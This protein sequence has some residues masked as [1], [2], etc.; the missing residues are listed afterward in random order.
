MIFSPKKNFG[1]RSVA[2]Q[3]DLARQEFRTCPGKINQDSRKP[4]KINAVPCRSVTFL[5]KRRIC[6][7]SNSISQT[8]TKVSGH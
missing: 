2:N 7:H 8:E 5:Q 6:P 4:L 3:I 1:E